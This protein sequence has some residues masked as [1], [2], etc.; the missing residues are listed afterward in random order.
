MTD[1]INKQFD[2]L[3]DGLDASLYLAAG[4]YQL[5]WNWADFHLYVIDP[6]I[7]ITNPPLIIMPDIVP[8]TDELEFVYPIHD[9]GYKLSA[10]KAQDMFSSGR[11]M[12]KLYYTI[13][14]MIS[15]LIERVKSDGASSDTEVQVAFG[16]HLLAQRKAFEVIINL[17]YNVVVTN[18]DPSTWADEY[19]EN[20]K[21][22]ASKGYGYP[23]SAPRDIY[24]KA[25][26]INT[27]FKR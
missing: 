26:K 14:K 4:V 25:H 8:G 9:F 20:V 2:L 22:M 7:D 5:W 12:C 3:E 15:I 6:H 27:S 23:S 16:G 21:I 18:F 13:E 1:F 17:D 10:S 11:S 24:K 19:L